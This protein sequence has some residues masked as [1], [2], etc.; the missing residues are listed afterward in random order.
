MLN[1][2][3]KEGRGSAESKRPSGGGR[4]PLK[5]ILRAEDESK[6]H[7]SGERERVVCVGPETRSGPVP[8]IL[9]PPLPPPSLLGRGRR[10][11]GV[12]SP[13]SREG[14]S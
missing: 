7:E 8:E 5:A 4:M 3:K 9:P 14:W 13:V 11:G 6:A 2:R 12:H 1:G 10:G